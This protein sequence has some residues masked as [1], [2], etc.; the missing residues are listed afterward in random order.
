MKKLL[1]ILTVMIAL[2][3]FAPNAQAWHRH[4]YRSSHYY[5][6]Y[7]SHYYPRYYGSGL[8]VSKTL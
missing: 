2:T 1:A 5:R 3:A 6:P 7:Y 4:Y 8:S